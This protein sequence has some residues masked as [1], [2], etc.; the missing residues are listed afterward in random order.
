MYSLTQLVVACL[1]SAVVFFIVGLNSGRSLMHAYI[2][3]RL[4][5][6]G[7]VDLVRD[8]VNV[9]VLKSDNKWRRK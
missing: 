9:E 3:H 6:L 4:M 7:G 5:E 2:V 8:Y 1:V